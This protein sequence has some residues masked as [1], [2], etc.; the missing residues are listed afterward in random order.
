MKDI[1]IKDAVYFPQ[2]QA[3]WQRLP[4]EQRMGNEAAEYMGAWTY[5]GLLV[6]A[7]AGEY[8]DGLEWLHVSVS[9]SRRIPSYDDMVLVKKHFI[10]DAKK[11]V[12]VLPE[13]GNH[14]NIHDYCL[15]MFYSAKN[16]LPE[17]SGGTGSI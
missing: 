7:S 11:A 12:F 10:G 8:D 14:V 13:K 2:P 9:R 1:K 16:P 17:F 3:I 5:N 4:I 15:H 6:I